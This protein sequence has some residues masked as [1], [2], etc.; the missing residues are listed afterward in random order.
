MPGK[1]SDKN[2][3]TIYCVAPS[4]AGGY[5]V[6]LVECKASGDDRWET[7]VANL[8]TEQEA[9]AHARVLTRML[10]ERPITDPYS[11]DLKRCRLKNFS[12]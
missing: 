9:E 6:L 11:E 5:D 1:R 2:T 3:R 8:D 12:T 4:D 10:T 7:F